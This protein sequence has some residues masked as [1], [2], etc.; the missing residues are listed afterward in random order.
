MQFVKKESKNFV[1]IRIFYGGKELYSN[2]SAT[3]KASIVRL[4]RLA[5][6]QRNVQLLGVLVM[7]VFAF[8]ITIIQ[9]LY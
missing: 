6:L 4:I 5:K 1:S 3:Q 2:M 7:Y 8:F 9:C